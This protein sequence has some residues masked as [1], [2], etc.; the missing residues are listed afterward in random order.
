MK[1]AKKF[2]LRALI[3]MAIMSALG[4]VL[5]LLE[6][7]LPMVI[8]SFIKFDFS[9]LPA[10]ITSFALGPVYGVGV[11][12]FKNLLHLFNTTTACVGEASNFVLGSFFVFIAGLIY[13]KKKTFKGA[14]IATIIGALVM[15]VVS[16]PINYYIMYPF[17]SEFFGLPLV[18]ILGMYKAILP[19]VDTIFEALVIFNLPFNFLKGIIDAL[20]CF[21]C[22]K[23]LSP[24]LKGNMS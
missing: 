14:I 17:Y 16:I 21:A 19:S 20:I 18:A 1:A 22:Y 8:P 15:A 13:K 9:E 4:Y 23:K 12:F 6:F 24:L 2:N 7:P 3:V 5:M 10:I 11:C